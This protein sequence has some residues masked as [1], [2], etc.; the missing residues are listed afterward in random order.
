M[1]TLFRI[2]SADVGCVQIT[3]SVRKTGNPLIAIVMSGHVLTTLFPIDGGDVQDLFE[4]LLLPPGLRARDVLCS[5]LEDAL[6]Y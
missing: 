1:V 2:V 3:C 5:V 4:Y 6:F